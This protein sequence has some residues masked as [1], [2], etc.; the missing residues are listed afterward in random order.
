MWNVLR[1]FNSIFKAVNLQIFIFGRGKLRKS[2][3]HW[4][5]S[6]I[7]F[8]PSW[9]LFIKCIFLLGPC[10]AGVVGLTMPR[11]CLFGD[12]VNT[13]SR[14]EST[15]LRKCPGDGCALATDAANALKQ[16][17]PDWWPARPN[18]QAIC[19]VLLLSGGSVN[20]PHNFYSWPGHIWLSA[21]Q[22]RKNAGTWWNSS[23]VQQG[24]S[25]FLS[26][27]FTRKHIQKN[28]SH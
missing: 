10:A 14:I 16:T 26:S 8:T 9:G 19:R 1:T 15:G 17:S 21:M 5:G 11:Y 28:I 7:S 4:K 27:S 25:Y 20:L 24:F 23:L 18:V 2:K 3:P 12:T 13:A 22:S 6:N